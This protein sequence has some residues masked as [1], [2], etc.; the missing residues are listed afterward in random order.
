MIK[1]TAH[2]DLREQEVAVLLSSDTEYDPPLNNRPW[3]SRSTVR[4]FDGLPRL[5]DICDRH[6][7]P[8]TLF[9][10]G[11]LVAEFPEFFNELAKRHE[12][13]CHSFA[14]EWLGTRPPP[15][16]IPRKEELAILSPD[17]KA[18]TLIRA[19]ESIEKA[20]NRR[21]K[22][23][24][25]PFNSIDHP[26][27]L[28]LLEQIGFET[29][30][31]LPCYNSTTFTP[32]FSATPT[33][34]VSLSNLWTEGKM[35]LVEVPFMVRPRPLFFHPFDIREEVMD[36]VS[37]GMKLALES[38]DLQC[39]IDMLSGRKISPVHITSHPWE[40]SQIGPEGRK[41]ELN[42]GNLEA[43]LQRITTLYD[44]KF[45]TMIDFVEKWEEQ[46]C[47]IHSSKIENTEN[48]S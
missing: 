41:G 22:S 8:A 9:C 6:N 32:S 10:E 39:R 35:E 23:F 13:G 7:A 40:F 20:I 34:H 33:R 25:A 44:T 14:H 21:P 36:T 38:V 15:R 19:T 17:A 43:F 16:W 4:L 46:C 27:T 29:D 24:K 3:R 48:P 1:K 45:L 2:L 37:R 11:K 42:A 31:S 47:R 30:S 18:R 28:A 26:S 5:Q 12:I